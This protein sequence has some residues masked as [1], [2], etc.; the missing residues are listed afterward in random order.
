MALFQKRNQLRAKANK[1]DAPLGLCV[2]PRAIIIYAPSVNGRPEE[3]LFDGVREMEKEFLR[4]LG[5]GERQPVVFENDD[6]RLT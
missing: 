2:G 6:E 5:T 4:Q 3:V 1:A